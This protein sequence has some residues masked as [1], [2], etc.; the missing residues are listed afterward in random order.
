VTSPSDAVNLAL[1]AD[2]PIMVDSRLLGEAV[3][4][5]Y[6]EALAYRTGTAELAAEIRQQQEELRRELGARQ[7]D[8]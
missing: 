6:A 4:A 2:V 7:Q 5:H 8:P 3:T 1:A